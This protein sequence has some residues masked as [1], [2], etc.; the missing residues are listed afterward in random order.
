MLMRGE[1]ERNKDIIKNEK[2]ARSDQGLGA[3]GC[4]DPT[5]AGA[6]AVGLGQTPRTRGNKGHAEGVRVCAC[7]SE[8][9]RGGES[10]R[11]G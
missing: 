9:E 6:A 8:R 3:L 7:V 4:Q 11:E 10:G 2:Q 5:D 1:R